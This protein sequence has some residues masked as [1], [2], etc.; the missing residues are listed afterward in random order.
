MTL[1]ERCVHVRVLIGRFDRA[2]RSS[3][4]GRAPLAQTIDLMDAARNLADGCDDL[5]R[6]VGSLFDAAHPPPDEVVRVLFEAYARMGSLLFGSA[7][8]EAT[9][10][11]AARPHR[12][13]M[14]RVM[15]L[16]PVGGAS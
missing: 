12:V 13:V 11:Q 1:T 10:L 9:A 7:V 8:V 14:E 6:A 2:A 15:A 5:Q 16:V 4:F 3:G